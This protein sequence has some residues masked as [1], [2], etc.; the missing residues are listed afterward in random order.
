MSIYVRREP[1]KAFPIVVADLPSNFI[2]QDDSYLAE[3]L[4]VKGYNVQG[5]KGR[6]S[7]YDNW[8]AS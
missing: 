2:R 4:L 5:I 3:L 6:G 1:A 8:H 7:S